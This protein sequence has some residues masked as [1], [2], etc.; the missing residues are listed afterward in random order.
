MSVDESILEY[1]EHATIIKNLMEQKNHDYGEVM[2]RNENKFHLL[3]FFF[4][5]YT[6][7]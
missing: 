2:E 6:Q 4:K 3:I 1:K 5:N 7:N